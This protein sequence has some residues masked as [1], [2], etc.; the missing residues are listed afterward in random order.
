VNRGPVFVVGMNGSGTT[1]LVDCLGRHPLLYSFPREV[2]I[3]PYLLQRSRELGG[4]DQL[5][6]RRLLADELGSSVGVWY[7]NGKQPLVLADDKL[8]ARGFRG[9]VDAVF[10]EFAQRHGKARWIEKSP[11]HLAYISEL[12]AEIP[13]AS[14][15]HIVRD[16]RDCAQSFHRRYR[17]DPQDTIYRWRQLVSMGR[18][19][20]RQLGP[21]R[22]IEVFYESLTRSPE[23]EMRRLCAFL[24][25]DFVPEMLE[26]SMRMADRQA[27]GDVSHIV[28]N[29]EKWRSYFSA[30]QIDRLE[31]IAG[32]ALSELGYAVKRQGSETPPAWQ[33]RWA[34]LRARLS[35]VVMSLRRWGWKAVPGLL[36]R[37]RVALAQDRMDR[38]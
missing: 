23:A 29:S 13:D 35:L 11:G 5:P 19:Q 36:R 12:A 22:Y 21:E 30:G 3:L 17:Y 28:V 25:V 7:A 32:A 15:I 27:M 33:R 1:M 37:T 34:K 2:R 26:S 20:G 16:G 31:A 6:E 8:Q 24:G 10:S 18:L 14:F 38:T 9:V 4:L